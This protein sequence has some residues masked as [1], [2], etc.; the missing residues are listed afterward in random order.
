MKILILSDINNAHTLRWAKALSK[1]GIELKIFSFFS[2]KKNDIKIS[3]LSSKLERFIS[4]NSNFFCKVFYFIAIPILKKE[5]KNFKP[6]IIHAHYL[7]SYGFIGSLL[8]FKPYVISVW[9]SDVHDNPLENKLSYYL[10]KYALSKTDQIFATS[11]HIYYNIKKY[12]RYKV[13]I[14]PFGFNVEKINIKNKNKKFLTIGIIKRLEIDAGV[15]RLLFAVKSLSKQYSNIRALIVGD[16]SE[17]ANLKNLSIEL[18]IDKI[19]KFLG[20]VP[21][22][23]VLNYYRKIDIAVFPSRKESFGVSQIEAMS[24]SLPVIANNVGGISEI[25][26]GKKNGILINNFSISKLE[27][28]IKNVIENPNYAN[29]I[30]YEARKHVMKNFQIHK[31]ATRQKFFYEELL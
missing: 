1:K 5:I 11:N 7:S 4:P 21:E 19:T 22:N 6:D 25:I 18:K 14:L 12:G 10:K 27:Q 23:E 16:G 28:A 2:P 29:K 13:N 15:D 17:L 8:N 20:A 24:M 9:G 3:F 30:G 31:L 26:D